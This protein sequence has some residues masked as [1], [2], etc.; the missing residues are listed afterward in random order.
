MRSV[1]RAASG[2]SEDVCI[3]DTEASPEHLARGTARYADAMYIVVEPYFKSL[4]TG[5]RMAA[6]AVDL[7]LDHVSLIANK[8]RDERD[9][10]AVQEFAAL[11]GLELSGVIPFDPML[12]RAERDGKA[13]FDVDPNAPSVVAITELAE[14]IA[15]G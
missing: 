13:P 7:G 2:A 14:R 8:I 12:A 9:L 4:E 5:R 15:A 6:L 10:A 1:V 11:N 3:L